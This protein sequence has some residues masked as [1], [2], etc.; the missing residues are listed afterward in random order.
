MHYDLLIIGGGPAGIY[1]TYLAYIKGL[2]PLLVESNEYLGGQPI[3][4]YSQK[5]IHDYPGFNKIKAYKLSQILID[6]VKSVPVDILLSTTLTSYKYNNKKIEV[7]LSNGKKITTHAI[8]IACGIGAFAPVELEAKINKNVNLKYVVDNIENFKD[9]NVIVLGGGDS[10]V[11]WSNELATNIKAKK[12]SII[13]RRNEFRANGNNVNCLKKNRVNIYLDY[14]IQEI[15][16]KKIIIIHNKTKKM[17]GI[18]FEILLVQY[19][20]K[21]NHDLLKLFGGLKTNQQNRIP[22]SINQM[23]NLNN[24]YAIGNIC[25]YDDKP[26]NI[27][28]AHGE[29]AVAVRSI[30]NDIKKY[31][32][33]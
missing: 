7:S 9:K 14:S 8:I 25:I 27:I 29:A 26:S 30:L 2:K 21:I 1:A 20:Q 23:T 22:V 28:C 24:I 16:N 11:D 15:Q 19:G 4:L 6:Q 10:A 5:E 32:K 3:A 12:V 18:P 17:F 13:H 33:K 31:D